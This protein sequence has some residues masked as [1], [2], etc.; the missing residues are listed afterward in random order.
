MNLENLVP[1]LKLCKQMQEAGIDF[2][3]T[4]FVWVKQWNDKIELI[5][6][7][8]LSD[9]KTEKLIIPAPLTGELLEIFR[10]AKFKVRITIGKEYVVETLPKTFIRTKDVDA[11]LTIDESLEEALSK[12][13]MWCKDNGYV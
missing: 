8:D 1:S 6:R 2:G 4:A 11:F 7:K 10:I 9:T 13:L 5:L 12:L 3:D